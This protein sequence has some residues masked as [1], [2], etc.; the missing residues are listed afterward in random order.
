MYSKDTL[1]VFFWLNPPQWPYR[2]N[3]LKVSSH[4]RTPRWL[5]FRRRFDLKFLTIIRLFN[6]FSIKYRTSG[7]HV[8]T[9]RVRIF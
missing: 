7:P 3:C 9:Q 6:K 1:T 2:Y 4:A 5:S 8:K